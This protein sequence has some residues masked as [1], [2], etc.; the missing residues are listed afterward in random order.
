MVS[1]SNFTQNNNSEVGSKFDSL[2]IEDNRYVQIQNPGVSGGALYAGAL[3]SLKIEKCSFDDNKGVSAGGGAYIFGV[4]SVVVIGSQFTLN[5]AQKDS[6]AFTPDD[7][8]HGGAVYLVGTSQGN[9]RIE[10]CEFKGNKGGFGGAVHVLG[11]PEYIVEIVGC[12][13][14]KNEASDGGGAVIL[15][16]LRS[17][18]WDKNVVEENVGKKGGGLLIVNGASAI[19]ESSE[20][21]EEGGNIFRRNHAA[22]GGAIQLFGAGNQRKSSGRVE[23]ARD[24]FF[25]HYSTL[26]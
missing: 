5:E 20:G 8:R 2:L 13:F 9:A 12:H 11:V 18:E 15:R 22:S 3:E 21:E 25:A 19:L 17:V 24:S 14:E 4:E 7:S 26:Q 1:N 16:G 10:D 6:L 23:V